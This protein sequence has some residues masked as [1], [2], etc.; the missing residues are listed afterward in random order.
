MNSLHS[1]SRADSAGPS[2]SEPRRDYIGLAL[3]YAQDVA[4]GRVLAC[5]WVRLACARQLSDLTRANVD[6]VGFPYEWVPAKAARVCR[7]LEQLPHVKGE[8]AARAERLHLEPWQCF[9]YCA[10]FGWVRRADP[11]VRRF[12]IAYIAVPRKNAKSTL[13]AGTGLYMLAADGEFGAEVYAGAT[14]KKQAGEV[15]RPAKQMVERTKRLQEAFSLHVGAQRLAVLRNGSVFEAIVR[16][17]GDGSSPSCAIVDEYHEHKT[18]GLLDTMRTGMGA[19]KQPLLWIITTAG[20]NTAGPCRLMQSDVEKVLDGTLLQ[21]DVFGLVYTIDE[22]DD[23]T[24]DEAL[25]K[26][27][28]NY[29]VSVSADF[30]RAEQAAAVASARKQSVFQTKHLNVWVGALNPFLNMELWRGLAD[31]ALTLAAF[32]GEACWIGNDLSSAVDLTGTVLVFRRLLAGL[33]HYYFFARAYLPIARAA[34]PEHQHY[35]GWLKSGHLIGTPGETVDLVSV[36]RDLLADAGRHDVRAIAFDPW[37]A[38]ETQQELQRELGPDRVVSVPQKVQY[39]SYPM[40][41]LEALVLDGRIHHNGDP[42]LGWCMANLVARVDANENVFP[43]KERRENK[44][45]LAVAAI[46]GL[47]RAL[48]D[49]A[50]AAS[51]EIEIW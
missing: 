22:G 5:K 24:S 28:P 19:R 20:S 3:Q 26:A 35:Q 10:V 50:P 12:R 29:G 1:R 32:A 31:P 43:R 30:L 48:V 15:F 9:L 47:S 25:R 46:L 21:E 6:P 45:D 4:A 44:I 33:A 34:A 37:A 49:T 2:T 14:S 17:P 39:L 23:W 7:F 27:N 40:K 18:D 8:W 42:V 16:A 41:Q 13:A 51:L 11:G 36:R 38:V